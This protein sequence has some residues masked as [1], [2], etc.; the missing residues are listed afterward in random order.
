ME[1]SALADKSWYEIP[2]GGSP[3]HETE[4]I[5]Y[6]PELKGEKRITKHLLSNNILDIV[7]TKDKKKLQGLRIYIDCGDDDFLYKGNAMFHILLREK[8]IP[9]EYRVRNGKH[10]WTYWRTGLKDGLQ[11]IG[12]S[13]H[14]K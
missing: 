3:W 13:F 2:E 8:Q 14:Q 5:V 1:I 12:E 11:F 4:S 6:G 9:H 10:N 7:N